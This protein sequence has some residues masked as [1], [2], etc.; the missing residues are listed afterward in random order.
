MTIMILFLYKRGNNFNLI[1]R[2]IEIILGVVYFASVTLS[3]KGVFI[4]S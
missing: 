2:L 3:N 4:N 1:L